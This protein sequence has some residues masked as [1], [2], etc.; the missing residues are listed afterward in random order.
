MCE[1]TDCPGLPT[2]PEIVRWQRSTKVTI[3]FNHFIRFKGCMRQLQVEKEVWEA[4]VPALLCVCVLGALP[5]RPPRLRDLGGNTRLL[6]GGCSDQ[7][8]EPAAWGWRAGILSCLKHFTALSVLQFTCNCS[9]LSKEI[10]PRTHFIQ[11]FYRDCSFDPKELLPS[12]DLS[13][14]S[15]RI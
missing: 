14:L 12:S 1:I 3:L 10:W 2:L 13:W 4:L 7:D 6:Q 15:C 11:Q 9:T 5:D 8:P